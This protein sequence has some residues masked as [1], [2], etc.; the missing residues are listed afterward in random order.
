[1]AHVVMTKVDL[2]QSVI[3]DYRKCIRFNYS[4][5]VL[6]ILQFV[7]S[8]IILAT[9]LFGQDPQWSQEINVIPPSPN[10]ASFQKYIDSP[11]SLYTG[12]PDVSIPIYTLSTP[13]LILPIN[14]FYNTS[15]LKVEERASWVGAGFSL[16]AGGA[17]SRTS[18]GL[19]DE[20]NE[21]I[22]RGYFHNG[23]Y[24]LANGNF[25]FQDVLN[26][27]TNGGA[28]LTTSFGPYTRTDSIAQGAIDLE[29]DIFHF[30][31]PGGSGKFVFDIN[32]I[33]RKSIADDMVIVTHPFQA[34][35]QPQ[36]AYTWVIKDAVGVYYTFKHSEYT[37]SSSGCG[38][39]LSAY[40]PAIDNFQSSWYMDH[41]SLNG[42]TI[43]F[44]YEDELLVYQDQYSES[45]SEKV[46]GTGSTSVSSCVLQ[47]EVNAKRLSRIETSTG[48]VVYFDATISRADLTGSKRLEK[49][50][51]VKDGNPIMIYQFN[52]DYF[53]TNTKL[54]L[55]GIKQLANDELTELNGHEFE[56]YTVN[57]FPPLNSKK[58]DYWGYYNGEN[59]IS[60]IP[61]YKSSYWHVNQSS[62]AK[63]DPSEY[64]TKEGALKKIIYP[65]RGYTEFQYELHDY[66]SINHP[67]TKVHE[68]VASGGTTQTPITTTTNFTVSSACFVTIF[69]DATS[70]DFYSF[71][72]FKVWNGSSYITFNPTTTAGNRYNLPVGSY[73]LIAQSG[74]GGTK[75]IKVEFEQPENANI[76]IGGLRIKNLIHYDDVTGKKIVKSYSYTLGQ[77]TNS[78]G[79]MFNPIIIGGNITTNISGVVIGISCYPNQPGS[80]M[81]LSV[82]TQAPLTVFHGSHIGYSEVKEFVIEESKLGTT[83]V[84]TDK[85]VGSTIYKFINDIETFTYVFPYKPQKDMGYKN[86]KPLTTEVYKLNGTQ[87]S[88]VKETINYYNEVTLPGET[89]ALLLKSIIS[90][91]CFSCNV[92]DYAN[93]EYSYKT[94]RHYLDK[95]IENYFDGQAA[96]PLTQ[97][98][99]NFYDTLAPYVHFQTV[100]TRTTGSSGKDLV[101]VIDRQSVNP[102]LI[103]EYKEFTS[104][105]QTKG[106]KVNY[107]GKLISDYYFLDLNSSTYIWKY[108]Y[109][110]QNNRL[111]KTTTYPGIGSEYT[112]SYLWGYNNA[113]PIA[114]VILGK[115]DPGFGTSSIGASS[116]EFSGNESWT[117]D[118]TTYNDIPAKTGSRYYRLSEGNIT[119]SLA[120]GTY[121]LEYWAKS[122]VTLSGGT[123]TLLRTSDAD[124]NGWRLYESKVVA[125]SSVTLTLSGTAFIDELRIYPLNAQMTTFTYGTN[126][127]LI[128]SCDQNNF[129]TYY[130]YDL[131]GRL[132]WI[133]DYKG[134][135]VKAMDY[136]YKGF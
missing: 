6:V 37:S 74:G 68:A 124:V 79:V 95:T 106:E 91:L 77:T 50:R 17:V 127:S 109:D 73:R 125:G 10:V 76:K 46:G 88:K 30:S 11:I 112:K 116:F 92:S 55:N 9:S 136:H 97:K 65:T 113:Q 66:Y 49:I 82:F 27:S 39:M 87:L 130:D 123:I 98:I 28:P 32:R 133:K 43:K 89:K 34:S 24:V 60:L 131:F 41:M 18:K 35:A 84:D 2:Y 99:Y 15:G 62:T 90:K 67:V 31:T 40:N 20:L 4:K 72:E 48:I 54:K 69:K 26:C 122:P 85:K 22:R 36:G 1:M 105:I 12:T 47:T 57:S 104:S 14:L 135:I 58:Q 21:V 38:S 7:L 103:T 29:P 71:Q 56:Y 107:F 114:E 53:G 83:I 81:N 120:A 102:A 5:S 134:N 16:S 86:G 93:N 19:P 111:S 63:R 23:S 51:V 3:N 80:F 52:Y 13:Q 115:T 94:V 96:I 45:R 126:N 100:G 121:K 59:N 44:F 110:Y 101:S 128:S 75:Y 119:K 118:S 42:D 132:K 33:P 64:Y 117:H 108:H 25:D 70:N 8:N 129:I 78:S 61:P